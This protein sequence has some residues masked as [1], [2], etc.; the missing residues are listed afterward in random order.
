SGGC[1]STLLLHH[2]ARIYGTP[3][4]PVRALSITASQV[5]AGKRESEARTKIIR[6]LKRRGLHIIQEEISIDI[7]HGDGLKHHGLPQAVLWLYGSQLLNEDEVFGMGYVHGDDWLTLQTEFR[8]I[9]DSLQR[10][11]GRSGTLWT[12]LQYTEKRGVIHQLR[13]LKLMDKVWW[14]EA[15]VKRR[16]GPCGRCHSCQSHETAVWKL[17]KFGPGQ[18]WKGDYGEGVR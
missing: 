8:Q 11:A 17:E 3:Q 5:A 18:L 1:D 4:T 16:A 13:R 9:F 14:C 15:P 10:I 7:R 2:A 6:E 12:P